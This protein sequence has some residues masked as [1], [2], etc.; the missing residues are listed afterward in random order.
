M[1]VRMS[2][3]FRAETKLIDQELFQELRED[4][5]K[6][7]FRKIVE[8]QKKKLFETESRNSIP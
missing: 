4:E 2:E 3:Y 7:F 5:R 1:I 6:L 8:R